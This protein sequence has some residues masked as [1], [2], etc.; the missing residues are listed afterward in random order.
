MEEI[1]KTI[2]SRLDS[3]DNGQRTLQ[4]G[5]KTLQDGQKALQDGQ[6]ALEDGQKA[7]W[8]KL[9]EH[10]GILGTLLERTSSVE[11]RLD[12]VE[13]RLEGV[14]KNQARLELRIEN[15]V[16]EKIK[17]LFDDREIQN[18]R[19]DIIENKLDGVSLDLRYLV[20]RVIR[21]EQVAK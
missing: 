19:F 14:E 5:L 13:N 18:N 7:I 10:D 6:K 2:L 12:N 9:T 15:E 1:L 4:D 16:I 3:L 21:L 17:A 8:E 20:T 11:M